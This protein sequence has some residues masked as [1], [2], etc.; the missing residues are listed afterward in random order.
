[1]EIFNNPYK[2]TES[3]SAQ[4]AIINYF[5]GS[6][7]TESDANKVPLM[8]STLTLQYARQQSSFFPLNADA[9]GNATKVN[10][11]GAPSGTLQFTSIYCPTPGTIEDFLKMAAR[12]CIKSG[13]EMYITIRPFGLVKC[14][15]QPILKVPRFVLSAVEL[16]GLGLNIQSS[17]VTLV[18]MPLSFTFTGLKIENP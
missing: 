4:G 18:N 6:N 2:N 5:K 11:K 16:A 17:E 7:G 9:S 13:D 12:D 8:I 14:A 15:D 3:W 1:M 10:I